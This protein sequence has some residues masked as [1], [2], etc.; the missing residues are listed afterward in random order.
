MVRE[1]Q[2]DFHDFMFQNWGR[3]LVLLE[4]E[5]QS[6]CP[7]FNNIL[8]VSMERS[9]LGAEGISKMELVDTVPT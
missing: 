3:Y 6:I 2:S 5:T 4:G 7:H 1:V 9:S 8:E